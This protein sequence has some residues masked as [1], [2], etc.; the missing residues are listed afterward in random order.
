MYDNN[1]FLLNNN[2]IYVNADKIKCGKKQNSSLER[3]MFHRSILTLFISYGCLL[4]I[5]AIRYIRIKKI[6]FSSEYL[7]IASNGFIFQ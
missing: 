7:K 4:A 6:Y 5:F 2:H 1:N 3:A